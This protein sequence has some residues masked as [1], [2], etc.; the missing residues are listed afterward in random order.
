MY[1]GTGGLR[2]LDKGGMRFP[3]KSV[4]AKG[5]KVFPSG[6]PGRVKDKKVLLM[7]VDNSSIFVYIENQGGT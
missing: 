5:R 1:S 3:H 6:L 2:T 7:V 4:R